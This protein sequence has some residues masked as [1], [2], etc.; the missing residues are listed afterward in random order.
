M[1]RNQIEQ[2]RLFAE[3]LARQEAGQRSTPGALF[4]PPAPP[5]GGKKN[6]ENA[7]NIELPTR[8][9][10]VRERSVHQAG[11]SSTSVLTRLTSYFQVP[12]KV[13][14]RIR[15]PRGSVFALARTDSGSVQT[16]GRTVEGETFTYGRTDDG[17]M[18]REDW[19][20]A[21]TLQRMEFE[22]EAELNM[23]DEFNNKE[24]AGSMF[25]RQMMTVSTFLLALQVAILICMID[26]DGFEDQDIN[27]MYGPPAT[28]LVRW[29]AKE[30][31]MMKYD[32]QWWR[33]FSPIMLHAG[34]I[35][36]LTNGLIQL[37]VGGYLNLL[38]GTPK[39]LLIYFAAGV[40]GSMLSVV[41]LPEAVGVGASGALLG[42]LA[43]WMVWIFFRWRKIPEDKRS[44]RNCQ[45][46]VVLAALSIT[47]A[48][49]F[50]KYVDFAAHFGGAAHGGLWA[51]VLLSHELD[52]SDTRWTVR[53]VGVLLLALSWML[54]AYW[55]VYEVHPSRANAEYW[56]A[57][58]DW[59]GWP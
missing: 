26:D 52:N 13:E 15:A 57:N 38:F 48:T 14:N 17:G 51:M 21:R 47:L 5:S 53:I 55:M 19:M 32:H 39:W 29:G 35:H 54:T 45:L 50:A 1:S 34:I 36:M 31:S 59:G 42:N 33:L 40:Y 23:A 7:R 11:G 43:A 2:D 46:I 3:Q 4:Q 24:Y 18:N 8:G 12:D 27:P 20:I 16:L 30:A 37:R 44:Q 25:Y 28:T 56:E 22:I 49:S 9:D 41:F 58:D 6:N 10:L